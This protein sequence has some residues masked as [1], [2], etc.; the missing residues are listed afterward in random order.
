MILEH[1][2]YS[3]FFQDCDNIEEIKI[4][5]NYVY[6]NFDYL[7]ITPLEFKLIQ[8]QYNDILEFYPQLTLKQIFAINLTKILDNYLQ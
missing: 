1:K 3:N 5:Y 8:K 2:K 7:N 4:K 6:S